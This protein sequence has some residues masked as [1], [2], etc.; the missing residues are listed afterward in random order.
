[1]ASPLSSIPAGASV[2]SAFVQ[3][4]FDH[5]VQRGVDAAAVLQMQRPVA[6]RDAL[7]PFP[8]R[9]YCELLQRAAQHLGDPLFG[10]ALGRSFRPAHLGALGYVLATSDTL[11]DA[12]DR[13]GR[14]HV[15]VHE[16]NELR[17][18]AARGLLI[19]EWPATNGRYGRWFEEMGLAA[20]VQAYRQLRDGDDPF[21]RV[22]FIDPEP[23]DAAAYRQYFGGH[24][25]FGED[26]TRLYIPQ[27][28]LA[29]PF[30]RADAGLR[31]LLEPPLNATLRQYVQQGDALCRSVR[32]EIARRVYAG[33]VTIDVVAAALHLTV[34]ELRQQLRQQRCSFR[35]LGDEVLRTLAE[36]HLQDP[37]L[38]I[39]QVSEL[40]GYSEQSAFTRAFR[41]WVGC[42]PRQYRLKQ[43][44]P[45][46]T[47]A[48]SR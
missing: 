5:L 3:L 14:Y 6:S 38:G 12:L 18:R 2:P 45:E 43:R 22:D 37:A 16:T 26:A 17:L 15:L 31:E 29:L 40:L 8:A 33:P 21:P 27:S 11:G 25:Q 48:R 42:S 47:G 13:V 1:M 7:S 36:R 19:V 41:R 20:F 10:L 4:L 44:R 34:R 32:R 28:Y 46:A 35:D 24:V 23:A 39:Q 9:Q 30:A